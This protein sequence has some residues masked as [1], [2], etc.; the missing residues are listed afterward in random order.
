MFYIKRF[1]YCDFYLV[2][3]IRFK[4]LSISERCHE[5]VGNAKK[6]LLLC[7]S[8][9]SFVVHVDAKERGEECAC[10]PVVHVPALET[11]FGDGRCAPLPEV[12]AVDRGDKLSRC[13]D[14]EH[15]G[16]REHDTGEMRLAEVVE[17]VHHLFAQRA[18]R[19]GALEEP[20]D[21]RLD[22]GN[23]QRR[24]ASPLDVLEH[25]SHVH[26]R[27]DESVKMAELSTSLADLAHVLHGHEVLLAFEP[28]LQDVEPGYVRLVE[29]AVV[30][31]DLAQ[32]FQQER[33]TITRPQ[34][35]VGSLQ[36]P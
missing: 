26:H 7:P 1:Y 6:N 20:G 35:T 33:V 18:V 32:R 34:H 19:E 28:L 5:N 11:E 17:V 30:V 13:A 9:F 2:V 4:D 24:I 29:L 16:E 27:S 31:R 21:V 14:A 8:Y 10:H 12:H 22:L 25:L 23:V 36:R 3:Y 15:D